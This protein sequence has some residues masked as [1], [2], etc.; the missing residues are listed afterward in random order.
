MNAPLVQG[1]CPGA[2]RPM[3]SGDG[4][5]VR[6]RAHGGRLSQ[7]QARAIADLAQ[8]HGNGLIDLSARANL[9]LRGIGEASH[10]AVVTGLDALGLIDA[11]AAM[12]ARRNILVTPFWR[13]GDGTQG[14]AMALERAL[15]QDL[16]QDLSL[17]GKFGFALDTGPEPVLRDSSADIRIER[18][19]GGLVLR[20]EG[21]DL[22]LP[23]GLDTA[24]PA[25]LDLARWFLATGGAQ[26]GRGRM[27]AHLAR[28][29]PLPAGFDTP[30]DAPAFSPTL[31][32]PMV[33]LPFGQM[34]AA[35][36][37]AL[38]DLAPLRLTPWRMLLLEGL[39]AIPAL[40]GLVTDPL[41][42][43]LRVAACTG[44]PGCVQAL[45]PVRDLARDLAPHVPPG[46]L[47]HISACA[48]G[49]AHPGPADI[50]LAAWPDGFAI[51]HHATARDAANP[52]FTRAQLLADPSILTART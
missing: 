33:A 23:V 37:R 42:P 25:A 9:Q 41:D 14:L 38:A 11:D 17:P 3:A 1:W 7:D 52:V 22:A 6:I 29:I 50:T 15:V 18:R 4:L 34:E 46:R 24:I 2:L 20:P 39:D 35:T 26:G 51:A 13:A 47:L 44:A 31:T 28:G 48:K 21:S 5:V 49:C 43:L 10:G 16:S 30:V 12:E 32:G 19:A 45:A 27:A 8:T 36:L 40:P